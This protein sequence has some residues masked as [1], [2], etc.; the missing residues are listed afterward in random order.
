M[1]MRVNEDGRLWPRVVAAAI[2]AG[3][4]VVISIAA[5]AVMF[6]SESK[7]VDAKT[8]DAITR[9]ERRVDTVEAEA[10]EARQVA[11]KDREKIAEMM[12]ELRSTSRGVSRIEGLLD[13]MM[14]ERAPK[15]P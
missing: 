15:P 1:N 2:P 13:R 12:A 6:W 5:F 11:A 4:S 8:A 14:M 10:R 3:V 7:T 9:I